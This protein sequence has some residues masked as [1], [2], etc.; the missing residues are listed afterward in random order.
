MFRTRT[1]IFP[2]PNSN[3]NLMQNQ[4]KHAH[5]NLWVLLCFLKNIVVVI[6]IKLFKKS[7]K[8][9]NNDGN[10]SMWNIKRKMNLW[11]EENIVI[12]EKIQKNLYTGVCRILWD[13]IHSFF[14][15]HHYLD[16]EWKS[17]IHHLLICSNFGLIFP[18]F[19]HI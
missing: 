14:S 7:W 6:F 10:S 4:R 13:H 5:T 18:E 8:I 2:N 3:P 19:N 9:D 16:L 1:W 11:K 17:K 12:N 15:K